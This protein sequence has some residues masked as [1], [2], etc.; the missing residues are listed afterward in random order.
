MFNRGFYGLFL[1]YPYD[2]KTTY[3]LWQGFLPLQAQC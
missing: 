1:F 2:D 3:P